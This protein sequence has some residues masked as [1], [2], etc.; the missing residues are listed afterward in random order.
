MAVLN[1]VQIISVNCAATA[2][3]FWEMI[4]NE[5]KELCFKEPWQ[6]KQLN[7]S[8]L[9]LQSMQSQIKNVSSDTE[10][11]KPQSTGN[12]GTA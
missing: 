1:E 11:P 9:L 3:E 10:S 6:R 7:L 8:Q 5:L 4:W 2:A 12:W